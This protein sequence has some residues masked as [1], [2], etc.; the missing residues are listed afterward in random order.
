MFSLPEPVAVFCSTDYTAR[1][2]IQAAR[3]AGL[4]V[5]EEVSVVGVGN[6]Y[7]DSLFSGV[8]IASVELPYFEVGKEAGR[9]LDEFRQGRLKM[10]EVVR[11][12]PVRVLERASSRFSKVEDATVARA[13]DFMRARF[14]EAPSISIVARE[15]GVSRRL[16]EQKFQASLSSTPYTELLRIKMERACQL[17]VHTGKKIMEISHLCGFSSQHQFSNCFK[18]LYGVSPR[19]YRETGKVKLLDL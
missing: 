2:V 8:P 5:P 18:R 7:R 4:D 9:M 12:A 14:H 6:I 3:L 19:V 15:A 1:R 10:P 17:L 11:F 13:L 16:L